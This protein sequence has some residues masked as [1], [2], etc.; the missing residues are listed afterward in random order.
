M[1]CFEVKFGTAW[2]V[3]ASDST[4]VAKI[5]SPLLS[6]ALN[7]ECV[8]SSLQLVGGQTALEGRVEVCVGGRWGT[9]CDDLWDNTDAAVVCKSLGYSATSEL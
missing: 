2:T 9:V 4:W 5:F 1:G 7:P 8:H 6:A 3:L